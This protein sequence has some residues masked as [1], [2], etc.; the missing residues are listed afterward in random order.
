MKTVFSE[1][2]I[3][4]AV[5]F[6]ARCLDPDPE[7]AATPQDDRAMLRLNESAPAAVGIIETVRK[8][9][10]PAPEKVVIFREELRKLLRDPEPGYCVFSTNHVELRTDYEAQ[11]LLYI[12]AKAA[13]IST[14]GFPFKTWLEL[15]NGR[16]TSLGL[17]VYQD[18]K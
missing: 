15:R 18:S 9:R 1:G 7:V 13:G 2:L 4:A 12:A 8:R 17:V 10:K 3:N 6:W 11:G 16:A 14:M 5:E